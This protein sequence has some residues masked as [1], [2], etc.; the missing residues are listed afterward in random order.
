MIGFLVKCP[1]CGRE[2]EVMVKIDEYLAYQEGVLAK[3]AFPN[4]SE[5]EREMIISGICIKCQK[6]IFKD[7]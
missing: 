5:E 7:F 1:I 6:N 2:S 3:D 4:L